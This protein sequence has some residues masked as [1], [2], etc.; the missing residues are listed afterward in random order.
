MK[1][2][3]YC[4]SLL[5][6]SLVSSSAFAQSEPPAEQPAAPAEPAAPAPATQA[7][8]A[9][10]PAAPE[11]ASEE[12]KPAENPR[13]SKRIAVELNPIGIAIGRYSVQAE[14]IFA[15]RHT[16]VINPY[17][18][19]TTAEISSGSSTLTQKFVGG[20]GELGYRFY[21]NPNMPA[22]F[23]VGPSFIAGVYNASSSSG[24]SSTTF[25]SIG[26]AIDIGGQ[27][28]IGPGVVISG[29]AGLQ[30]TKAT[31]SFTDL[32]LAAG[33]IGAAGFVRASCSRSATRSERAEGPFGVGHACVRTARV[34]G[35]KSTERA[36][37][38][39]ASK[40]GARKKV[41]RAALR[42]TLGVG[43]GLICA[44]LLVMAYVYPRTATL[45][46]ERLPSAPPYTSFTIT[47]GEPARAVAERLANAG[48]LEDPAWFSAYL[49]LQRLTP[50]AGAHWL[51]A[52]LDHG[53]LARRL[54]RQGELAKVVIPEGL[55]RFDIARKL[56]EADVCERGAFL[57][58]TQDPNL[59]A[60]LH[61]RGESA[62]GFL[63][64]ATYELH[65]DSD[66]RQVTLRMVR[67]L[68]RRLEIAF[69][70]NP[71][72]RLQLIREH[73]FGTLEIVTLASLV[74]R[75]AQVADERARIAS[76]FL[77]RLRD[78]SATHRLLQSDPASGYGCVRAKELTEL[79][80]AVVE[81]PE[82]CAEYTGKITPKMNRDKGNPYSTYTHEG[83]PPGPIANPGQASLAAVLTPATTRYLYFVARGQG[84]HA[85]AETLEEHNKNIAATRT[86]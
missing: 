10:A 5:A 55:T 15:K 76:V 40:G 78:P 66:P 63:F 60:R 74:E 57:A 47:E 84:R 25:A 73:N 16:L 21:S 46:A 82:S 62:E 19:Y 77:N 32:P 37:T 22:G 11:P 80:L 27:A 31:E 79:K 35:K 33:V 13:Y 59:L 43:A 29:G 3:W 14:I 70:Q 9:P 68:E 36:K 71:E 18:N 52:G 2:H 1:Y 56:A 86:P 65:K 51:P 54:A 50:A 30:Y 38:K 17:F 44:G 8:P 58:A 20:G 34:T 7:A 48:L 45:P 53:E 49:R 85:F 41:T 12:D 24:G 75:E 28:I 64:P 42:W 69:S 72:G 83:L 81:L 6:S 61:L 23:Y 39:R 67:E 26:G 4:L